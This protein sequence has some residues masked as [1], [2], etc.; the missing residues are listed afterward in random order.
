MSALSS[1]EVCFSPE[2]IRI[3]F[4]IPQA[5]TRY[6]TIATSVAGSKTAVVSTPG[7][8]PLRNMPSKGIMKI[9][10]NA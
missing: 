7:A 3:N 2:D 4:T 5:K 10:D 8:N 1:Y 9:L 6:T